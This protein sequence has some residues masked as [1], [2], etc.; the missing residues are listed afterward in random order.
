M[1]IESLHDALAYFPDIDGFW[2]KFTLPETEYQIRLRLPQD[3]P[4][5]GG[6]NTVS[7]LTQLARVQ[8]LSGNLA[9]ARATLDQ[10]QQMLAELKSA[11]D[12]VAQIRW[13]LEQGRVLCLSMSPSKANDFFVRAW[14]LGTE[15]G[16][17]FFAV[18]AALMLSTIR[19]PRFQNEW[20]QRALSLAETAEEGPVRLWLAHLLFLQG[21]HFFDFRQ[22]DEALACFDRALTQPIVVE[23][24][25]KGRAIQWSRGRTLR[26][27]DRVEEALSIQL[28]L[29][30]IMMRSGKVNGHV[31]LEI[32]ECQQLLRLQDEAKQNFELA[33]AELSQNGW[34]SDNHSDDL[35]RM[36]YLSKKR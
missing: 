33:Y 26:A 10:A 11:P 36:K 30:R 1:R 32:A 22:F 35:N 31:Y 4:Q 2:D 25:V 24:E 9:E 20:L 7:L 21:W 12:A 14:T 23:N 19:P 16:H 3:R 6:E 28:D 15:T 18:D 29:Q 8:A 13:L 27:L 5:E 34:Y 17:V